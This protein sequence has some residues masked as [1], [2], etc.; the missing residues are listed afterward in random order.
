M[1]IYVVAPGDSLYSI[2]RRYGVPTAKIIR[3]NELNNPNRLV[4]GQ[5]LVLLTDEVTYTVRRGDTIYSIAR[6]YS[7]SVYDLLTAN[8][9]VQNPSII[10]PGLLL[11]IPVT[12]NED[13]GNLAVNGY[14][15]PNINM[16]VLWKTLPH[17]TYLSIFSYQIHNDG[18]LVDIDDEPLIAAARSANVAPLMVI[19]N[20]PEG[21]SFDSDL[22][23]ILLNDMEVQNRLIE[24]IVYTLETKN[25]FGLDVDF[26]YIF[27]EDIESYNAFLRKI[28]DIL[29]PL[30]YT[31]STAVAPKLSG[32]QEGLLYEGHD[33]VA[34]GQIVDHVIIMTYEW[35]YTYGPPMAV[36]PINEVEK[37]IQY[38]VTAIPRDKILMGIP[39]YGYEWILPYEEGTAATTVTN[40]GAV[41][42]AARV[43]ANIMFDELSQ[44][45]Y[46]NYYGSDG[47]QRV[48]WFEDARSIFA[49]LMLA[50]EYE[51]E[52]VSYWTIGS[53]FPQNWL[54]LESLYD[55]VKML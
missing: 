4:I 2:S 27:P 29:H 16:G 41:D 13:L 45:P 47:R 53:F 39:N 12:I 36:A 43:G 40:V 54:V 20:M 52:G 38:A 3:D 32:D 44:A 49:K 19:T 23:H 25:Y 7:I 28:T 48:V 9:Q 46:F 55:V 42:L 10:N 34:H 5:T 33:Y 18:N 1:V 14:A 17:L 37:V 51:L 35:G 22:A 11:S 8:P 30:G 6:M 15:F 50:G 31:V 21:G 24:N 26:E